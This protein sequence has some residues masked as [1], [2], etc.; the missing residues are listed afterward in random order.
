MPVAT[1]ADRILSPFCRAERKLW[2]AG[3]AAL[4]PG[5]CAFARL[6]A[7]ESSWAARAAA[8]DMPT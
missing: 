8:A 7:T 6:S 1:A 3:L 4:N 2:K 5:D